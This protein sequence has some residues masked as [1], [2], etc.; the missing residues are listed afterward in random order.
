MAVNMNAKHRKLRAVGDNRVP[1]ARLGWED[2]R[3]GAPFRYDIRGASQVQMS[4]YENGRLRV[5]VLREKGL[6]VPAWNVEDRIP[7]KVQSA[8]N[9][10][11]EWH[12]DTVRSGGCSW[13]AHGRQHW[14]PS[15]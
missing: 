11:E 9:K 5:L 8:M 15:A 14:Q 10:I 2:A 12:A 13:F 7:P 4:A 3:I 1:F 6:N